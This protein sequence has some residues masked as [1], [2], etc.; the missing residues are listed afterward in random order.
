[1][2]NWLRC[3]LSPSMVVLEVLAAEVETLVEVNT[4][5]SLAEFIMVGLVGGCSAYVANTAIEK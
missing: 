2:T 1:M 3:V 4:C 5:Q